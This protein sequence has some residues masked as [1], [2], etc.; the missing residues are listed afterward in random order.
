MRNVRFAVLLTCAG[1]AL[2]LGSCASTPR[3]FPPVRGIRTLADQVVT[4][5]PGGGYGT[6][7]FE[8][9]TGQKILITMMSD[10]FL[11]EPYGYLGPTGGEGIYTPENG[12]SV[13]GLNSSDVT[14]SQGGSYTLTVF[15]GSNQ[16]GSVHVRI[17]LLE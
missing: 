10:L 15:D 16:G 7:T 13:D 14:I 3:A 2:V 6:V 8:A 9:E 5:G 17:E 12:T 11:L 1:F 4:V